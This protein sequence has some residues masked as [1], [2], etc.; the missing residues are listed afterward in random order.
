MSKDLRMDNVLIVVEDFEA[1]KAFFAELGPVAR[2]RNQ[3]YSYQA[4]VPR[5]ID[6][7]WSADTDHDLDQYLSIVR[8]C[9]LRFTL[10]H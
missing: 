2:L 7:R 4:V 3:S 6:K 10:E 8:G 9:H 1:A 5:Y